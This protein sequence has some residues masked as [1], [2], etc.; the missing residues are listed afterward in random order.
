MKNLRQYHVTFAK[1]CSQLMKK[2]SEL[3]EYPT[4]ASYLEDIKNLKSGFHSFELLHIPRTMN[5][6]ADNLE[7]SARKQPSFVVHMNSE[8]PVWFAESS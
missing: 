7:R 3:E 1:D 4:F 6:G 8:L 2:V 5:S